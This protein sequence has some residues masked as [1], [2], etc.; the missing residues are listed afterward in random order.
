MKVV[1]QNGVQHNFTRKEAEALVAALPVSLCKNV[2]TF[3]LGD[4]G[5]RE[6]NVSYYPKERDLWL[7]WDAHSATNE[8]KA[9][10]VELIIVILSIIE[11]KGYC[12]QTVKSSLY[13]EHASK[14]GTLIEEAQKSLKLFDQ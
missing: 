14:R 6:P 11:E 2:N 9:E 12:P 5:T 4:G 7:F 8:E 3:G 10:V 13:W 1:C